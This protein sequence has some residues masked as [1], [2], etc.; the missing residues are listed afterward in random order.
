MTTLN[1]KVLK[2]VDAITLKQW[3]DNNRIILV[4]VREP[5][6]YASEHLPDSVLVPLSKFELNKIP[7]EQDQKLVLYCRTSNRSAQAAKK[8]FCCGF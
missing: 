4:D 1:P 7:V 5:S 8:L 2:T 3:F 6:E